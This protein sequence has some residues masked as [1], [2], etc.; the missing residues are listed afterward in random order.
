LTEDSDGAA[1]PGR[2]QR[3]V[4]IER[5]N[6]LARSLQQAIGDMTFGGG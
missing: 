4:T 3:R 2:M 5:R 1:V 6:A